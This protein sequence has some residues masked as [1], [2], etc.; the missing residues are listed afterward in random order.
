MCRNLETEF[1]ALCAVSES[2]EP[3]EWP[4]IMWVI[5]NRVENLRYPNSIVDVVLQRKQFSYWNYFLD[6]ELP[7][8]VIADAA[9]EGRLPR[10]GQPGMGRR[11]RS[12]GAQYPEAYACAEKV[13]DKT[14]W[15]RPFSRDVVFFYSPVSMSGGNEPWWWEADVGFSFTP[16]GVDPQ[17]FVFGERR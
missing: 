5:R 3:H 1:L 12:L 11:I 16:S 2:D 6:L 13:L 7:V 17:R 15:E 14:E 10:D 8:D 4:Y 9:L